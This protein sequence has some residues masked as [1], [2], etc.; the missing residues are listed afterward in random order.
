MKYQD[1]LFRQLVA[2]IP[3]DEFQNITDKYQGDKGTYR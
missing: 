3:K 1:S 2:L